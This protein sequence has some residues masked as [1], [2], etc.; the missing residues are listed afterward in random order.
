M[1]HILV[2]VPVKPGLSLTLRERATE[3]LQELVL[4]EQAAHGNYIDPRIRVCP[5]QGD[6]RS[7][8]GHAAA[9][10][11]MLDLYL[12]PT[13]THV[14]W[15]DADLV[16]YPA[17]MATRLAALSG[18]GIIAPFVLI[19]GGTRFYDTIGFVDTS[20]RHATVE[21]PYLEGGNL[22]PMLAVGCC[23]LAP[24]M[25]FRSAHR[26]TLTDGQ[27]E[28][29][30]ICAAALRLGFPVYATRKVSVRH[31]ALPKYGEAYH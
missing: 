28:H 15:I 14:L 2:L 4:S 7:Y 8:S 9:R 24:A 31:A 18:G 17:D 26:Y 22:I 1:A 6:G 27:T 20:G 16:E 5:E 12:E 13:H 23:Y 11:A 19:E 29:Y 10:N 30:S 25:L 21:P 3:L